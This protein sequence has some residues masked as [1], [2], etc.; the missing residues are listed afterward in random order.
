MRRNGFQ[1][2]PDIA[3]LAAWIVAFLTVISFIFAIFPALPSFWNWFCLVLFF[4]LFI[5]GSISYIK[6]TIINPCDDALFLPP[7]PLLPL[8]LLDDEKVYC[9]I[10]KVRV[11]KRTKHCKICNKCVDNF[12][13]HC[14]WTN[15][16]VSQRKN[17]ASFLFLLTLMSLF[18]VFLSL[19]ALILLIFQVFSTFSLH[20]F[21]IVIVLFI[22]ITYT[23]ASYFLIEL[24][25]FHIKLISLNLTTYEF[26]VKTRTGKLENSNINFTPSCIKK[27]F[28]K[29]KEISPLPLK[30]SSVNILK[31]VTALPDSPNN[32]ISET[33][34]DQSNNY[35]IGAFTPGKNISSNLITTPSLINIKTSGKPVKPSLEAE[36]PG[37][38]DNYDV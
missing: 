14:R 20:F 6:C 13:H 28:K 3:Q 5:S 17:Y 29:K 37:I 23:I 26:I 4:S 35:D 19:L 10:C 8:A 7:S 32:Q 18:S 27:H 15:N 34:Q 22:L 33:L 24:L 2:P 12:D 16:C 30:K 21:T 1:L 38:L 25:L 31:E 9:H 36:L 11:G